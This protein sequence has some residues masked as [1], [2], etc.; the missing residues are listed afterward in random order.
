MS[1]SY[2]E[3]WESCLKIIR[4]NIS[5][6]SYITWFEPIVPVKLKEKVLTIQV[7]SQFFYEWLEEHYIDLL[8]KTV[9]NELGKEGRL[10]YSIIVDNSRHSAP[11]TTKLPASNGKR[12]SNP[13]IN[14]PQSINEGKNI[15]NPFVIPGIRK[16]K[17]NPQLKENYTFDNFIE[18]DCNRLARSAGI[19]VASNPG[20]TSF[21]PLFLY[22]A[23]G[24]GKTHLA[25]AIGMLT[26]D[27]FPDKTVL[28][29]TADQFTNQFTDSIQNKTYNDFVHFYQMI[30]VLIIDDIN[31]LVGKT[32]TQEIF[33]HIFN[34]MHQ[35]GKQLVITSDKPPAELQ[36]MEERLL[37]RFKWGLSAE[38][39]L[40]EFNT[41]VKII[42]KKLH[43]DGIEL[44]RDV[45]EYL[46]YTIT[47]NIRE[48]EGSL[49]SLIA[50]ASF[51][52]KEIT[53]DLAKQLINNIIKDID[54]EV[55][56]DLIKK[57]VSEYFKVSINL[58]NST[59]RK[60][61]VVQARQ[62]VMFFAKK[63]TKG[64]LENIGTNC[65]NKDHAT[66]LYACKTVNNLLDTD[67]Q[68]RKCVDEIEKIISLSK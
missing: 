14:L 34:Q 27:N 50:Q 52:R 45:I 51:N 66:V 36:G 1:K 67:K 68:Y 37:S 44:P 23:V 21:N 33:F 17:I 22:S 4:D 15:P 19:S 31:F 24:L 11:Q 65:G 60:R 5:H 7:P 62:L 47:T 46:A 12:V 29:V 28:Y 39:A 10:E 18:G 49:I 32:R 53:L 64:S 56:I 8:R 13:P 20:K 55:S 48:L 40:P 30:D 6:Q 41:R 38:L 61:E 16:I 54:K 57:I 43:T 26:K 9:K 63:Y 59:T 25:H 35:S 42:E 2:T 3:V 58:I